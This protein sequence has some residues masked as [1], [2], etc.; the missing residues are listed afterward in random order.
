[1][2]LH[3]DKWSIVSFVNSLFTEAFSD[4]N[5][6]IKV[7][8]G[9]AKCKCCYEWSV[10]ECGIIMRACALAHFQLSEFTL[11]Q[12]NEFWCKCCVSKCYKVTWRQLQTMKRTHRKILRI[13]KKGEFGDNMVKVE[14]NKMRAIIIIVTV[15]YVFSRLIYSSPLPMRSIIISVLQRRSV[16]QGGYV[17]CPRSLS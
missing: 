12:Q 9:S 4:T 5:E 14:I 1:M 7:H 2:F 6:L 15:Y 8:V 17:T 10:P 11:P 16:A 13:I 3:G